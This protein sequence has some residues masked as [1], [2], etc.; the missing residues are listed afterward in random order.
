MDNR[1][2]GLLGHTDESDGIFWMP[3]V[4]F[5]REFKSLYICREFDKNWI[6]KTF[7]G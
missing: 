4:D 1:M 5:V 2:K 3:I 6:K 7:K